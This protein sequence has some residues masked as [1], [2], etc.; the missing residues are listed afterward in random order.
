MTVRLVLVDDDPIQRKLA[1]R[2]LEMAGY[3]VTVAEDGEQALALIRS[4]PPDA[5]V[6]DVV[7]PKLDGFGLCE[8]MRAD[9]AIR[10]I[11]ILLIT[12][13]SI[14][15]SDRDLAKR[16]GARDLIE[17]TPD[18]AEVCAVLATLTAA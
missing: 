14:D 12:N 9:P 16:S 6:S 11:P 2:R 17:R 15:H 13:W 1:T 7:M 3:Q 18:F 5:V 8:A 10:H 4:S